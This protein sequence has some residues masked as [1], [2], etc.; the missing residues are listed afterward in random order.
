MAILHYAP[1]V[2]VLV[3]SVGG[4]SWY[5]THN[6]NHNE[7]PVH[8]EGFSSVRL[9]VSP[10]GSGSVEIASEDSQAMLNELPDKSRTIGVF[11]FETPAENQ[12]HAGVYLTGCKKKE[13]IYGDLGGENVTRLIYTFKGSIQL[14]LE[15]LRR[16]KRIGSPG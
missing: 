1:S 16:G 8:V 11:V 15:S 3:E 14:S 9:A 6:Y 4:E 12:P 5:D 10:D 2:H 13:L 7:D